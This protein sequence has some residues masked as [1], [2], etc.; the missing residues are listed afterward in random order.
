MCSSIGSEKVMKVVGERFVLL[1]GVV[2]E[3]PPAGIRSLLYGLDRMNLV[4]ILCNS[5]LRKV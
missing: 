2:W 4:F 5:G 3:S 1:V